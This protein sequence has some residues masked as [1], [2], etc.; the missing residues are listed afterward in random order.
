MGELVADACSSAEN[1]FVG[2]LQAEGNYVSVLEF[3]AFDFFTV[4]KK[5]ATLA[6]IFQVETI[7]FGDDSGAVSGDTAVG[8]LQVIAGF[9]AAPYAERCLRDSGESPSAVRRDNFK[10]GF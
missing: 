5:A 6:T 1:Y 9:R 3:A 8:K 4:Y 7:C 10:S 2:I